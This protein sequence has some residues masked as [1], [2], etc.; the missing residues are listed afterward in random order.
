[1]FL[2]WVYVYFKFSSLSKS[3]LSD[4]SQVEVNYLFFYDFYNSKRNYSKQIYIVFFYSQ[5]KALRKALL[6]TFLYTDE[7]KKR[8]HWE[9]A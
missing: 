5:V 2:Y 8:N 6:I 7:H 9:T 4:F 3:E 1:M